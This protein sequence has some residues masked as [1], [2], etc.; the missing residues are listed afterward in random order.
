MKALTPSASSEQ[1]RKRFCCCMADNVPQVTVEKMHTP[2]IAQ[3]AQRAGP[4]RGRRHRTPEKLCG[5][6][7]SVNLATTYHFLGIPLECRRGHRRGMTGCAPR[8]RRAVDHLHGNMADGAHHTA[9]S[10]FTVV[11]HS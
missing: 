5:R 1:S 10:V 9:L 8:T 4:G 3:L 7:C 11:A 2:V 6:C